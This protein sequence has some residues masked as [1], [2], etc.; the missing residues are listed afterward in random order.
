MNTP[1]IYITVVTCALLSFPF[2]A[3]AVE[4][5]ETAE[6]A[7]HCKN[8]LAGEDT[9]DG[10]FCVRYIQGFIDG[11]VATD[12]RVTL[13]VSDEYERDETFTERA[14][15]TRIGTRVK[16]Y[17][18]SVYAG[19]CLGDPL[20]LRD[21]VRKVVADLADAGKVSASPLAR[22]LVYSTLTSAYPCQTED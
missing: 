14:T 16:R 6:L 10:T 5:L 13:S 12:E 22:D 19:Y 1:F 21:V 15:R 9:V 8:Y 3:F 4:A 2:K 18:A 17:G 7:S 11:A 20:P